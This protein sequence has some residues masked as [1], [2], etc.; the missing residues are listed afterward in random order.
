MYTSLSGIMSMKIR[1]QEYDLCRLYNFIL[2]VKSINT[3]EEI[4]SVILFCF[5]NYSNILIL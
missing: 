5:Q 3:R 4:K 1:T 2:T